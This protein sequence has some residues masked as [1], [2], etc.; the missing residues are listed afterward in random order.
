M[1]HNTILAALESMRHEIAARDEKVAAEQRERLIGIENTLT[2]KI[3]A[4]KDTLEDAKA[5]SAVATSEIKKELVSLGTRTNHNEHEIGR[6]KLIVFTIGGAVALTVWNLVLT[7][8]TP[9]SAATR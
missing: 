9:I 6:L 7:Q 1:E 4:V 2:A 3:S 5:S 8:L